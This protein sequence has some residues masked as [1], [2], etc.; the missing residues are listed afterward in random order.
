MKSWETS[1]S[2]ECRWQWLSCMVSPCYDPALG[3]LSTTSPPCVL[4]HRP[5]G[6]PSPLGPDHNDPAEEQKSGQT[7]HWQKSSFCH[8]TFA[9]DN[10]HLTPMTHSGQVGA[11]S[12]A[13]TKW[14]TA[15][16]GTI[17][18]LE[19]PFNNTLKEEVGLPL[20]VF[21]KSYFFT[22]RDV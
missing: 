19:L 15:A 20:L 16:L 5:L 3:E 14:S 11:Q 18:L 10:T 9:G 7:L 22:V 4:L 2:C 6:P 17:H 21:F 13:V 1:P 8:F 12:P